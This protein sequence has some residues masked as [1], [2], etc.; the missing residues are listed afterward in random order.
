MRDDDLC[1]ILELLLWHRLLTHACHHLGTAYNTD[2]IKKGHNYHILT[3]CQKVNWYSHLSKFI[4]GELAVFIPGWNKDERWIVRL[5]NTTP[6]IGKYEVA[7]KCLLIKL[8]ECFQEL[9]LALTWPP[10]KA[11]RDHLEKKTMDI[12]N[13]SGHCQRLI[14]N[15]VSDMTTILLW[16]IRWTQVNRSF[17]HRTPPSPSSRSRLLW[18]TIFSTNM[19]FVYIIVLPAGLLPITLK[20]LEASSNVRTPS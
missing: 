9:L 18:N 12:V 11:Q 10:F 4:H 16:Q 5:S 2:G 1:K 14:F 13:V 7:K 8:L 3:C 17:C 19:H 6:C 15:S 20:V